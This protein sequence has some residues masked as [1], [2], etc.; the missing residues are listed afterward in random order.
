M[1]LE[2]DGDGGGVAL[3]SL[4]IVMMIIV[5]VTMT[6]MI[7]FFYMDQIFCPTLGPVHTLGMISWWRKASFFTEPKD[8]NY[9][10]EVAKL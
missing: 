4:I 2:T 1:E 6:M 7:W 10:P 5:M 8:A 3:S 9:T